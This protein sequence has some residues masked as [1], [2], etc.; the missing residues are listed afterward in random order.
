MLMGAGLEQLQTVF[1]GAA[2]CA[3]VA[4]VVAALLLRLRSA[5]LPS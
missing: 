5:T 1:A 2:G 3:V 4:G